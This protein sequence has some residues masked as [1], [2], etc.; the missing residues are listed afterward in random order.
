MLDK[1][2]KSKINNTDK[3][4]GEVN[5]D[6]LEEDDEVLDLEDPDNYDRSGEEDE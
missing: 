1:N 5:D 6:F 3:E 4:K 2:K